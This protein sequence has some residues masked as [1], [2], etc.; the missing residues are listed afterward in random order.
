MGEAPLNLSR[1]IFLGK[2]GSSKLELDLSLCWNGCHDALEILFRFLEAHQAPLPLE[3]MVRTDE[4]YRIGDFGLSWSWHD[5]SQPDLPTVIGF[6]RHNV[7]VILQRL[8]QVDALE[9]AR[10]IDK[11]LCQL[12]T[13]DSY[14]DGPDVVFANLKSKY[15]GVPKVA[16]GEPLTIGPAPIDE[17]LFFC[18]SRGSVNRDRKDNKVRYYRA[19]LETGPQEVVVYRVGS[20]IIPIR[21]RLN[22]EVI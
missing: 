11:Q 8:E 4:K 18:T 17:S 1:N 12:S 3:R 7:V 9:I 13:C 16:A 14:V 15:K 22:I 10:Q 2:Q 5:D 21:E 19:P 20:G 6:V